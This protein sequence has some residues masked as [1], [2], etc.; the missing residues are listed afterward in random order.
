MRIVAGEFRGRSIHAPKGMDT[1]PTTDRVRE[2]L[3]NLLAHGIRP[4]EGA[5]VLD[6]FSGSGALGLEALSRGASYCLFVDEAAAARAAIRRNVEELGLTGRTRIF[7][8][9]ATKLGDLPANAGGPFDVIFCDPPYGRG[10]G[11]RALESAARGGWAS[12]NAVAVLEESA[13]ADI[14]VPEGWRQIERRVYGDTAVTV[15]EINP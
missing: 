1:R 15:F 7:R 6:L 11:I 3:F 10:L 4:L 8:R 5:R 13:K 2:A 14:P 12:P 9:D